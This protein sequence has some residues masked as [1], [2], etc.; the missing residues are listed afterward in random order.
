M[1]LEF[2][3]ETFDFFKRY[4]CSI[5]IV[6]KK[7]REKTII[8]QIEYYIKKFFVS[9][10]INDADGKCSVLEEIEKLCLLDKSKE[11]EIELEANKIQQQLELFLNDDNSSEKTLQ[12][13]ESFRKEIEQEENKNNL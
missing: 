8:T 6:N 7:R 9:N 10:Y 4:I 5:D 3:D 12:L 11:K 1:S 2:R 13:I